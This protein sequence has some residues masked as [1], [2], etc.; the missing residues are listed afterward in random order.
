MKLLRALG[1]A[2]LVSVTLAIPAPHAQALQPAPQGQPQ[3]AQSPPEGQKPPSDPAQG[4]PEGQQ[5]SEGKRGKKPPELKMPPLPEAQR[6]LLPDTKAGKIFGE[7]LAICGRPSTDLMAKWMRDHLRKGFLEG[8]DARALGRADAADC[9]YA[10]GYQVTEVLDN[11]PERLAVKAVAPKLD[12]WYRLVIGVND[13][14][15]GPVQAMPVTPPESSLPKEPKQLSDEALQKDIERAAERLTTADAFSGIA[16]AARDGKPF[17]TVTAGYA[18]RTR[19]RPFSPSTQFTIGSMG[20]MFTAA[21]FAQLVDQGQASFDDTVG[22][23]F[24][25]TPT[26]PCAARS[27]SRCCSRTPRAWATSSRSAPPR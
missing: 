21:A 1:A 5:P 12:T 11:Q 13:E 9:F 3:A 10:G 15:S 17:V 6:K 25:D 2:I 7:W 19:E 20:K 26:R 24:P 27:P 18:D 14:G 22:R 8:T 16:M 23:F 4:K